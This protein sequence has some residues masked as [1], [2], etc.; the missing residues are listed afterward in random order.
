[1]EAGSW[2]KT[3]KLDLNLRRPYT[4]SARFSYD[5]CVSN[6]TNGTCVEN[7]TYT[8]G[9]ASYVDN[10]G[11]G[12]AYELPYDYIVNATAV[13]DDGTGYFIKDDY[14]QTRSIK[15]PTNSFCWPMVTQKETLFT[16]LNWYET[17]TQINAVYY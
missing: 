8:E 4:L 1:M 13:K 17:Q 15:I 14:R 9:Q 7:R 3:T 12:F 16:S 6:F 10:T 5:E 11:L 2:T